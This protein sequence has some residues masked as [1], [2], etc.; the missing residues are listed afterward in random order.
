[1]RIK[2]FTFFLVLLYIPCMSQTTYD[3]VEKLDKAGLVRAYEKKQ[4]LKETKE[5]EDH[6]KKIGRD[7]F[8]MDYQ[9]E[10][11]GEP[12]YVLNVLMSIKKYS[13]AGTLSITGFRPAPVKVPK[14]KKKHLKDQLIKFVEKL[15]AGKFVSKKTAAEVT[16]KIRPLELRSEFEVA[17]F[18]A[19]VTEN[20]YFL[21]EGKYK[22]FADSLL[23]RELINR[24]GYDEIMNKL[25]NGDF[26]SYDDPLRYLKNI[27][28]IDLEK[29]AGMPGDYLEKIYRE[30][31]K[32]F[33][34]LDFDSLSF[35]IE[36]NK[37][38]S[39]EGF[40]VSDMA[41][42]IRKE[43]TW[44]RYKSFFD[45]EYK[46]KIPEDRPVL[47]EN[48]FEIFNKIL[49]DQLSPFRL[50]RV[51]INRKSFGII[52]LT[53][54]QFDGLMWSYSGMNTGGYIQLSYQNFS[55]KLTQRKINEAI[56]VYDSIGL[57]SHLTETE[58]NNCISELMSK[59]LNYYADILSS[60]KNLVFEIDLEY[61]VDDGQY[62]KITNLIADITKG[63][64]APA[65]IID[66]YNYERTKLF[67][68][69]FSLNG[70]KYITQ[71]KQDDDWLDLGFWELIEKA[72]SEQDTKGKFYYL[73]PSDGMRQIYLTHEQAKLLKEKKMIELE[74]KD[75]KE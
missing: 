74:E 34:G 13:V 58:K 4:I 60:F 52:A 57:F 43:N 75:L 42:S 6:L 20:E 1:M 41:V 39:S 7:Q 38:E 28:I 64:F 3:F 48:Y 29:Y 53:K 72:V 56:T 68:Y 27:V 24:K 10:I 55:S 21:T 30:T 8:Q 17:A 16:N 12:H 18:V 37:R 49:A 63:N 40:V 15:L 66:T 32:S 9:K 23:S 71:L 54:K 44:Y 50:H 69:G 5:K 11:M 73:H 33:P 25:A 65:D 47:P 46:N 14:G 35:S 70:K 31:A 2:I 61:G 22:K 26:R 45:A 51:M 67:E 19:D 36:H 62:R 59:E